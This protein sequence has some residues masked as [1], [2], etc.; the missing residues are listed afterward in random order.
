MH[1]FWRIWAQANPNPNPQP[2]GGLIK[3]N[4][5]PITS[6]WIFYGC[7]AIAIGYMLLIVL[8]RSKNAG[9]PKV[10]EREL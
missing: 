3:L 6:S 9:A 8:K 7:S 1:V 2:Q 10:V 5:P 4:L